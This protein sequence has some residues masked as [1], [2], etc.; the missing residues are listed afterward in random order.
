[1]KIARRLQTIWIYI[2]AVSACIPLLCLVCVPTFRQDLRELFAPKVGG[3]GGRDGTASRGV[4][5]TLLR[6][7]PAPGPESVIGQ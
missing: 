4:R 7:K 2:Y 1:M 3:S 5:A 6:M